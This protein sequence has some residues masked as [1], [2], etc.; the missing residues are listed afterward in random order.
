M[1][2]SRKNVARLREWLRNYRTAAKKNS[3]SR[4]MSA[5]FI[6]LFQGDGPDELE[7]E[8]TEQDFLA[9]PG[10]GGDHPRPGVYKV[11]VITKES[12]EDEEE[13]ITEKE[14]E[15]KAPSTDSAPNEAGTSILKV[16][17]YA[18]DQARVDATRA[19]KDAR[20]AEER[21]R[22]ANAELQT[23]VSALAEKNKELIQAQI[24]R[25]ESS[26]QRELA[27]RRED[28]VAAE[29]EAVKQRGEELAPVAREVT[30]VLVDRAIEQF[31]FEPV[32][33]K[34][35]VFERMQEEICIDLMSDIQLTLQLVR[36]G[37][38]RWDAVRMMIFRA[39]NVDPGET[40]PPEGWTP[41]PP[42]EDV[43]AE[44]QTVDSGNEVH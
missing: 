16:M 3:D 35:E 12:T 14:G 29:L 6:F 24:E 27:E 38:L 41:P 10:E 9:V 5:Q 20:E 32:A 7:E 21:A 30:A 28:A 31:G 1:S 34:R 2:S 18:V 39:Y 42:P 11:K 15:W 40:C 44:G 17:Q 22:A 26:Y 25:D 36:I 19:K 37:K 23:Y 43:P 4:I 13:I 33:Q 8:I